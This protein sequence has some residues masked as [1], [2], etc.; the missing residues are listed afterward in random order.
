MPRDRPWGIAA[1]CACE[2]EGVAMFEIRF[3]GR[4]G[5]GAVTSA[6]L[7]AYA[8]IEDGKYGLDNDLHKKT[9]YINFSRGG[10]GDQG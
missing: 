6:E 3:H 1:C 2:H 9:Y 4:G 7:V 10:W 8:A 5:Q